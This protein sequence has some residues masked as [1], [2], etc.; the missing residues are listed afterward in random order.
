[1]NSFLKQVQFLKMI[2]GLTLSLGGLWGCSLLTPS[3][4]EGDPTVNLKTLNLVLD[5]NAN[6]GS[7]TEVDLILV[8]KLDLL[9]ALS[10]MTAH[11]YFSSGEQIQRDYPEMLKV[12][13]WELTPGQAL[14][15]QTIQGSFNGPLLGAFIFAR[16]GTPGSHRIR[17]GSE[18]N[19]YVI[20]KKDDLYVVKPEE[21]P[22]VNMNLPTPL[23]TYKEIAKERQKKLLSKGNVERKLVP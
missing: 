22:P 10:K 6:H 3:E 23:E 17:I 4:T 9:K 7:A 19:L 11:D 16:Y 18:E 15:N 13:H 5:Q 12:W 21:Y 14:Y 1:M 2:M 20:L 8:Y